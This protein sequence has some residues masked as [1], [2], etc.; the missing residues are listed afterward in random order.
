MAGESAGAAAHTERLDD[1]VTSR[2]LGALSAEGWRVFHEVRWPGRSQASID[3][4]LVGP[5]GVFVID[6]K[7]WSGEVEIRSGQLRHDGKR[8]ARHVIAS[9]AAAMAIGELL[10]GLGHKLIHPVICFTREQPVFGWCSDVMVCSTENVV[11]FLTS[12]PRVLDETLMTDIAETLAVSLDVASKPVPAARS[13]YGGGDDEPAPAPRPAPVARPRR[14]PRRPVPQPIKLVATIGAVAVAAA[15]AFQLDL[16]ARMGD[17]GAEA[18]HRV[19]APTRPIG[20]TIAVPGLGGRP[21]LRLTAGRPVTAHSRLPG[22]Q[23][24]PGHQLVAIPVAVRNTGDKAW[25]SHSDLDAELTDTSGTTY[26]SDPAYTEITGGHALPD[27]ITLAARHGTRG[28]VVFEVPRGTEVARLRLE[29]GP[30]LPTMVR[31]SVR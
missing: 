9:S 11:P 8:R 3:H 23:V 18:A 2:A 20:T 19:V 25:R 28:F 7:S 29:V 17:L 10:P 13:T 22:V 12:R 14:L 26:S 21:S 5:A 27:S 31:W 30:G 24:T 6:T 15:V 4:V 1:D 16:P